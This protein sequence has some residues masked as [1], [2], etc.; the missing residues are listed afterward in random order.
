MSKSI[1]ITGTGTDIGKTYVS[2]LIMETMINKNINACYFKP[3]LSGAEKIDGKIYAGDI[4]YVKKISG[5]KEDTNNLASFVYEYPASPHLA[6]RLENKP[7]NMEKVV[8]DYSKLSKKYEYILIEGAGGIFC[9]F[10]DEPKPI[11]TKDIIK[12]LNTSC[13]LVA[14]T[15]L[16]AINNAMLS[17]YYI[18]NHNIDIKGIIFNGYKDSIIEQDNIRFIIK[19]TGL[20]LLAIV[21]YNDDSI[22]MDLKNI[23]GA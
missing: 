4:E 6:G 10:T 11:Y 13:I 20:K 22:N 14:N 8:H 1:F 18:K 7:F 17:V 3:V 2:A 19:H 12:A 5:L 16:G 21:G 15:N 9:P 23:F